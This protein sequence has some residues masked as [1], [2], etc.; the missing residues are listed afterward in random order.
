MLGRSVELVSQSG[1][2]EGA[3][4]V[5]VYNPPVV[6]AE[7]GVRESYV[8]AAVR[9][10]TYS[11]AMNNPWLSL[12]AALAGQRIS[13]PSTWPVREVHRLWEVRTPRPAEGGPARPS[14]RHRGPW[15][16]S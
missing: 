1:A 4:R 7:L 3:R 2:P 8:K 16:V 11:R 10:T 12:I 9:L 13:T 14:Q 6:N 5:L 15:V